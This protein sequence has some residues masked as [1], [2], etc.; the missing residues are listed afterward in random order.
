MGIAALGIAL[1][2]N[3]TRIGFAAPLLLVCFRLL[4]GFAA[5]GEW[6]GAVT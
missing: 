4:Q 2:P 3:Y 5:G 1:L 6:G